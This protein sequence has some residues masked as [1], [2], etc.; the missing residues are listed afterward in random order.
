M[1]GIF[2]KWGNVYRSDLPNLVSGRADI[3]ILTCLVLKFM[4]FPQYRVIKGIAESQMPTCMCPIWEGL[5]SFR[6]GSRRRLFSS[7]RKALHKEHRFKTPPVCPRF[8]E[9]E[10]E[11][12]LW[13][14]KRVKDHP[15]HLSR[16]VLLTLAIIKGLGRLPGSTRVPKTLS[17]GRKLLG[18][19]W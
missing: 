19:D 16:Q 4:P 6:K 11:E 3:W 7:K 9:G 5:S 14:E 13:P 12:V 1:D 10:K 15:F 8:Q 2:C 18:D 17:A